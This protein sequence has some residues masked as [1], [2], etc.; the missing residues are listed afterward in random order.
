MELVLSKCVL[1]KFNLKDARSLAYNAN[2]INVANNLRDIFPHPYS[3]DD[4]R[5]Y[6]ENIANDNRNFIRAIVV[7]GF[8]VGS[9]GIHPQTDVYR[10]NAEIGYWLGEKYWGQGIVTEA[11]K[12]ITE[13]GFKNYNLHRI[14]A[15]IFEH[16][17]GSMRVLEKA[18]YTR[19]AIHREAIIKNNTIM[20]EYIY[21]KVLK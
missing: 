6:I 3:E 17:I 21:A 18:G 2:N 13:Y 7:D 8:S 11:A 5:F 10:K 12:A 9:I 16:N 4:A 20:D 1:R 15:G 14:Y 19:E